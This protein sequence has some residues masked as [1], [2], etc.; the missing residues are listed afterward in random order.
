MHPEGARYFVNETKVRNVHEVLKTE[1][2]LEL[3]MQRTFTE[4]NICDEDIRGDIEYYMEFLLEQLQQEIEHRKL[5][6]DMQKV[7]LVVEP[8]AFDDDTVVC[9]YYFAN[10]HDKCLFWLDECTPEDILSDCK[11]VES[12]SHTGREV[13][14]SHRICF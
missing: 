4:M 11:G 13:N 7:D 9:C 5:K 10:H 1:P 2:E 6:L 12:L 3:R 14:S 8:K